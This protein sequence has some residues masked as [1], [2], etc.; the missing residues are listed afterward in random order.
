MTAV[1]MWE[2]CCVPSLLHGAGTWVEITPAT[3]RRLNATQQ[4]Y[5]R[6]IYQV[7]PGAPLAS[8][9]WDQTCLDMGVR[10]MQEKVLLALHL[11]YLDKESLAH[12]VYLEQQTMGWPGLASEVEEI[13]GEL[14]IENVNTTKYNK[15]DYKK[16]LVQACH[17]RNEAI[18][19]KMSEGKEKCSRMTHE[20]YR[21]KD[22]MEEK[23][24]SEVRNIYRSR[25]GQ[26]AFAGNFSKDNTYRKSN[27]MCMCG[28]SKEKEKHIKS[29]DCPVYSDIRA[30]FT[31]F[32]QDEDLV[33]YFNM[34]LERRDKISSMEQDERDFHD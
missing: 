1:T 16:I 3:V 5:W 11:R 15:S 19:R 6:L 12:L 25:F 30:E 17:I 29:Y 24:I 22:Y 27:W 13:C 8:L 28:E 21:Q 18:L 31:N 2:R 20:E 33:A 34:V 14:N 9:S 32:D 26:R 4:W 10:V 23:N 7:G